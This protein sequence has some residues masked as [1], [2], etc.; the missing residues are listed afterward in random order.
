MKCKQPRPRFGLVKPCQCPTTIKFWDRSF[1]D[2]QYHQ[3]IWS[4]PRQVF[5]YVDGFPLRIIIIISYLKVYNCKLFVLRIVTWSSNCL[6]RIIIIISYLKASNCKLFVL[7]IVTWSSNCLLR[8]II[9]SYLKAYNR[10]LF[11][12]RIVTWSSNCL[13]RIIIIGY[14][15]AYNRKLFVLR[16]VTWSSKFDSIYLSI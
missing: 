3:G 11:V 1:A 9:I 8:I 6:L 4:P 16:I 15:K 7:R 5:E 13:L 10:K 12:S 14:L 2:L